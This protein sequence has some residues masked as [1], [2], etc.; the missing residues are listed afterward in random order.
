MALRH[1]ASNSHISKAGQN[2][3]TQEFKII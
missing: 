3:M 2:K 1:F